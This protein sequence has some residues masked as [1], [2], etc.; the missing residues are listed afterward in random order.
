[1]SQPLPRRHLF[2]TVALFLSASAVAEAQAAPPAEAVSP[3]VPSFEPRRMA[4]REVS[5]HI[6]FTPGGGLRIASEDGDF[7]LVTQAR[8]QAQAALSAADGGPLS[9][10]LAL[11]RARMIFAGNVFSPDIR[12]KI[13]LGFSPSDLGMR[14]DLADPGPRMSPLL[15]FYFEFRQLRDLGV[16]VGQGKTP[17]DRQFI[18]S[19]GALQLVDL[20]LAS[21]EFALDR[22]VGVDLRSSDL[23]GLGRLRYVAGVYSGRGRDA[24]GAFDAGLMYV[25][26]LEVL[27]FGLFDDYREADFDRTMRPRL[28]L[29]FSYGFLDR[30]KRAQGTRG[31][32]PADGGTTNIHTFSADSSF[33]IAGFSFLGEFFWR[34]G[35][36]HPGAASP[37]VDL[38]RNGYGVV[39]QAGY[40][41]PHLPLEI[42]GR[43]STVQGKGETSLVD[44]TELGG[45]LSWYFAQHA[46]KLQADYF[47]LFGAEDAASSADIRDGS[48]RVRLQLT[49]EL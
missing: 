41:I 3:L 29:A 45:G 24:I 32:L 36:R 8:L 18:T 6:T 48:H 46:L 26:R 10:G 34:R 27:P 39:A 38:A 13:E 33:K 19:A 28:S 23:F 21:R 9:V 14:N 5:E 30:A 42:V 7:A 37:V 22:D 40:L 15:D 20:A 4:T 49:A 17:Y 35:H 11:R 47:R 16:R 2:V 12:F 31:D 25:G 43:Y 1:M 44:Q